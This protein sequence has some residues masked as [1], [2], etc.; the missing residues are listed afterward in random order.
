[1]SHDA[2]LSE[3]SQRVIFIG[4]VHGRSGTNV[5]KR[6]V[7]RHPDVSAVGGGETRMLE[8]ICELWPMLLADAAYCPAGA[9]SALARFA[10]HVRETLGDTPEIRMALEQLERSLGVGYVRLPGRPRLPLPG[11]QAEEALAEALGTFVLQSFSAAALNPSLPVLCEK[12]PSNA[13]YFSLLRRLLPGAR[14]VVMV[15]DP[16]AV[17]LSHTQRDWGPTDPLEAASY[18]A[19]YFRRWRLMAIEDKRCLVVRHEDLVAEPARVFS[20]V[21]DHLWL[22][23]VD[24]LLRDACGQLRPSMDR[25]HR[26]LS[27][28]LQAMRV[29]LSD[30]LHA[31]GYD[32]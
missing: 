5:V 24:T 18:T 13:L 15:R 12:T 17:A 25:R 27:S 9:V 2:P 26:L 14:I 16:V 31:F 23:R 29:R 11:P 7:C 21:L 8:A 3:V 1:L 10:A 19:A 30:E 4:G 22:R 20:L 6:L 32:N 28:Q